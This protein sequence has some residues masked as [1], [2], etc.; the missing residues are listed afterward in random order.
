MVAANDLP[1]YDDSIADVDGDVDYAPF[2]EFAESNNW[3]DYLFVNSKSKNYFNPDWKITKEEVYHV[4]SQAQNVKIFYEDKD[5]QEYIS[6][7]EFAQR[8]V[9]VFDLKEVENSN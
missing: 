5:S 8:L 4:L 2:T 3:L 1:I 7:G 6:R 9:D